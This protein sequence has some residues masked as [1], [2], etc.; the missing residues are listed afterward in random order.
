ML[1]VVLC[2][3]GGLSI[4]CGH[5]SGALPPDS[6]PVPQPDA[7]DSGTAITIRTF[8]DGIPSVRGET[9]NAMMVAFQDGDGSW[10]PLAGTAGVYR[11]TVTGSRYGV[12]VGCVATQQSTVRLYYLSLT[13]ATDLPLAGCAAAPTDLV[14]VSID[15]QGLE[16]GRWGEVSLGTATA[17]GPAGAPIE[18]DAPRGTFDLFARSYVAACQLG[19]EQ[20]DIQVYRGPTV[21]LQA[22]ASLPIDMA[23][24]Q[25]PLEPHP[26]TLVGLR[27]PDAPDEVVTNVYRYYT[28]N[29]RAFWLLSVSESFQAPSAPDRYLTIDAALRKPDDLSEVDVNA[30]ELAVNGQDLFRNLQV[31]FEDVVAQRFELPAIVKATTPRAENTATGPRV[32]VT[33][34]IPRSVLGIADYQAELRTFDDAD[35]RIWSISVRPGWAAGETSVRITTPDLTQLSGW[36]DEMRLH[37]TRVQ[38]RIGWVDRALPAD[39]LPVDGRRTQAS[40]VQGLARASG[41]DLF[42]QTSCEAGQKCT[43]IVDVDAT[44]T[45]QQVGHIGCAPDGTTPHG[46]PCQDGTAVNVDTCVAGDLCL[47]RKC[48]SICDPNLVGNSGPGACTAS[49][50]CDV[51]AGLFEDAGHSVAGVC[52]PQCDPLTQALVTGPAACGSAEPTRPT[53]TCIA[54]A[55]FEAFHCA[56]SGAIL[57]DRTDRVPPLADSTTGIPFINGCAPGFMPFYLEGTSGSMRQLCSGVCAP[58]K[59]DRAIAT[60]PETPANIKPWGDTGALGK[61]VADPAPVAG[62][63]ICT[64][65]IKGSLTEADGGI[66]DCRFLWFPLADGDPARAVSSPFNDTLGFCFAYSKFVDVIVPGMPDPQPRKSC[67]DLAVTAQP[68]DPWGTAVDNGCYPLAESHGVRGRARGALA[69][70][71]VSHGGALSV[72][73]VFE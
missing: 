24:L 16:S 29:S 57:Y 4:A 62:H 6:G 52:D 9:Q 27:P 46:A 32:T 21:D 45:M 53:A 18:L 70:V 40:F 28:P 19:C 23:N 30:S 48:K 63:S 1:R 58:V 59:M 33:I 10:I 7:P 69:G 61:L 47:S 15:L 49:E 72:R 11:A 5:S 12:A 2:V 37:G 3:V 50:T 43:W 65:G 26:L 35:A 17:S 13:D 73:H 22:D 42:T 38:W 31:V 44:P 41:C 64:A 54:T 55:G 8:P 60:S 34:P 39:T 36:R 25:R 66:E 67:A 68:D 20:S 71:R 14:H 51:L 56:P